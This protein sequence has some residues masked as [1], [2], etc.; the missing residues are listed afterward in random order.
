MFVI[1]GFLAGSLYSR[2]ERLANSYLY[3]RF[4]RRILVITGFLAG[5]LYSRIERRL[6]AIRGRPAGCLL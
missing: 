2:I 5:S 4:E 3:C 6:Y 1:T